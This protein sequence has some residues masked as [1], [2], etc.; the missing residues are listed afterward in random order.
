MVGT[1]V[2]L[3]GSIT[4]V[5]AHALGLGRYDRDAIHLAEVSLDAHRASCRA[6]QR[7]IEVAD[8][9]RTSRE[10]LNTALARMMN[11]SLVKALQSWVALASEAGARKQK[12]RRALAR[13]RNRLLGLVYDAWKGLLEQVSATDYH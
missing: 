3:A 13:M 5:T 7:W 6:L 8:T 11:A 1:V 9:A 10:R 2:G 12:L 4:T